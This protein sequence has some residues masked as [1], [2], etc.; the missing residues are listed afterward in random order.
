MASTKRRF[1]RKPRSTNGDLGLS[2]R[3]DEKF[4][5]LDRI[6]SRIAAHMKQLNALR[7]RYAEWFDRQHQSFLDAIKTVQISL[8]TLV[9]SVHRTIANFQCTRQMAH[10][11]AARGGRLRTC[12]VARLDQFVTFWSAYSRLHAQLQTCCDD[13]DTFIA[14]VTRMRV[15]GV[16]AEMDALRV[17]VRTRSDENYDFTHAHN[18]TENLYTYRLNAG[19]QQFLGLVGCLPHLLKK[20]TELCYLV[21]KLYLEQE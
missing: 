6:K 9:P 13:V 8:P 10:R 17:T 11:L 12:D 21:G 2:A 4:H 7:A 16:K 3:F 1:L 5:E 15:P 18:D 19:D 14:S 20:C